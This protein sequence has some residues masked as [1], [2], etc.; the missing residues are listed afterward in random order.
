MMKMAPLYTSLVWADLTWLSQE[1]V[2]VPKPAALTISVVTS[3]NWAL[4]WSGTTYQWYV[5]LVNSLICLR[6]QRKNTLCSY[7]RYFDTEKVLTNWSITIIS[8]CVC[9][10]FKQHLSFSNWAMKCCTM[11]SSKPKN[12][13]EERERLPISSSAYRYSS[14]N[15]CGKKSQGK[16]T[17]H[18]KM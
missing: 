15:K 4:Q 1:G 16:E 18:R 10:K 5:N 12:S 3:L 14:V 7:A 17:L 13:G 8:L 9:E 6:K 2:G 11:N